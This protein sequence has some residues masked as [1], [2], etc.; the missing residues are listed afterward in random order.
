V[1]NPFD[2]RAER[3]D[4]W[5]EK[6]FGRSVYALELE[7]LR[8]LFNPAGRALEVGV[9]TGRFA[10]PLGVK[11]GVDP[12]LDMLRLAR[13]RGLLV[14]RG[15]GEALPFKAASFDAVL[16]IVT[17]CFVRKPELVLKEAYRVLKRGGRL[18]LALILKETRWADHYLKKARAGHPIYRHARFFSFDELKKLWQ[19]YFTLER[20]KSVEIREVQDEREV[21]EAE[22]V[23]GFNESSAF[24]CLRLKRV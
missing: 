1:P 11:Y 20:V 24:T 7:C 6:P 19:G 4:A 8:S 22:L 18:Y 9:G 2:G 21:K 13:R 10:A 17:L 5:Y 14:V 15:Y 16:L 23:D 3:Y 12:S